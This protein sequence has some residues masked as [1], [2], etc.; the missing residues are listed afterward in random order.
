MEFE[1]HVRRAIGCPH[2]EGTVGIE[3]EYGETMV[4]D[5]GCVEVTLYD[6]TTIW[7]DP[8][9]CGWYC[10]A[11]HTTMPLRFY[12]D[13]ENRYM[14]CQRY[15]WSETPQEYADCGYQPRWDVINQEQP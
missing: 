10:A 9:K 8:G 2:N 7:A 13:S 11:A 5:C 1:E 15:H 3:D 6:G 4:T 12:V 14:P